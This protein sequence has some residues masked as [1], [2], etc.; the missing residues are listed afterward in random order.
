MYAVGKV[1]WSKNWDGWRRMGSFSRIAHRHRMPL[2]KALVFEL[3]VRAWSRPSLR[4]VL[5]IPFRAREPESWIFVVGSYNA[6]TT[7]VKDVILAHPQVAGMPVEGDTL[8]SALDDFESDAFPRGMFANVERIRAARVGAPP[9]ADRLRADWAPWIREG[10]HFLEKSISGS[11]RMPHLRSIFPGCRFI[12]VVRHPQDVASGIRKRSHPAAGGAYETKFLNQ[13]WAFFYRTMLEDSE[14]EDTAFC[15]YEEFIRHPAAEATRL[16][17]ALGLV[18]V[19][20]RYENGVLHIGEIARGIRPL[21]VERDVA[22]NA[23]QQIV[24]TLS[25]LEAK[26]GE[27]F[28]E[29]RI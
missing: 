5:R 23:R 16:F 8:T 26:L 20:L 10:H 18:S 22:T 9:S 17:G 21:P 6:G 14:P 25:A 3:F 2:W 15:S 11:M 4:S 29:E 19:N 12:C 13:Q 7:I 27:P 24:E 28:L 1:G